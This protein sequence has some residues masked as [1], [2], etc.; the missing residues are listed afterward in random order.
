[1]PFE[2]QWALANLELTSSAKEAFYCH[3]VTE[4]M[5]WISNHIHCFIW[6]AVTHLANSVLKP[7]LVPFT[8][9]D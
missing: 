6:A 7:Q 5:V 1:M 4:I 9:M 8:N 3:G 2:N